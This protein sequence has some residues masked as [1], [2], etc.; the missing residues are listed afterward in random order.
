MACQRGHLTRSSS[1]A[2]TPPTYRGPDATTAPCANGAYYC[3]AGP[4]PAGGLISPGT[5]QEIAGGAERLG[6]QAG[7]VNAAA[8]A[9]SAVPGPHQPITAATAVGAAAINVGATAIE[10]LLRPD[11]GKL[12]VDTALTITGSV[13]ERVPVIGPVAAPTTNEMLEAWKNSG[14]SHPFSNG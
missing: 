3:A 6:R 12:V 2:T 7:V 9:V 8:T 13:T 1:G 4:E 5:R 11:P 10:Q 14:T